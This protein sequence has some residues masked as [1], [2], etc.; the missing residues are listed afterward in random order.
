MAGSY[1]RRLLVTGGHGFV[2]SHLVDLALERG[3]RVR[4]LLRPGR[5]EAV[6]AGRPVEVARGDLRFSAGLADAVRGV[7]WIIHVAGRISARSPAEFRAVNV[8]GTRRLAE[9]AAVAAPGCSRFVFVSSQAAFGPSPDGKPIDEAS[10]PRPVS[11]YGPSKLAAERVLS[12]ALG[13]IPFT[14]CRPP[15]IYGP[16]DAALRPFFQLASRGIALRLG[17][18][19]RRFD[20]LHAR[21]VAEALLAACAAPGAAG[22]AYFLAGRAG[23]S[24]EEFAAA[25]ER[26]VGRH[27]L[28]LHLPDLVLKLAGV[29]TDEAAAL[30]GATPVFGRQK[31]LELE[32]RWWLCSAAAARRD[33]AWRPG[34]GLAEGV[35]ATLRWYAEHGGH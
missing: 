6:F 20:L 17:S 16:R 4:C 8:E 34:I 35:A 31:A 28:R 5:S 3:H 29:L 22:R 14:I 18:R 25:L 30:V 33:L 10:S 26:A 12:G 24:Y 19:E 32:Q 7:D 1:H 2:G 23:C 27:L 9:A 21:D 15:A 11:H 13:A